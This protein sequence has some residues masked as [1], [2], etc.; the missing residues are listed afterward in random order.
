MSF[1]VLHLIFFFTLYHFPRGLYAILRVLCF[2]LNLVQFIEYGRIMFLFNSLK[3]GNF[4]Q[5]HIDTLVDI[6][7]ALNNVN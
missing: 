3:C 7:F 4:S 2:S 5:F 6:Q 1:I